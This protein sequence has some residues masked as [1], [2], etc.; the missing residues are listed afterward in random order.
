MA[1]SSAVNE[2]TGQTLTRIIFVREM[3][4]LCDLVFRCE[5]KEHLA[6]VDYIRITSDRMKEHYDIPASEG[7]C[8][9]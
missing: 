2:S 7:R 1:Y 6:R 4:L 5:P 9:E 8:A 3:R